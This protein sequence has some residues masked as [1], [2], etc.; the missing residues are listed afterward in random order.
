MIHHMKLRQAPF[1][2]I[3]SHQKQYEFR[4]Y[5]EKRRLIS[6]G[7]RIM[8]TCGERQLEVRVSEIIL[9]ATWQELEGKID[10][11]KTGDDRSLDSVMR[12]YYPKEDEEKY[13]CI[14]IAIELS[15]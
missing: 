10:I 5:D 4:L 1:D 6:V 3:L 12:E 15:I 9:A 11:L 7:D 8:F 13:G 2:L 14:A